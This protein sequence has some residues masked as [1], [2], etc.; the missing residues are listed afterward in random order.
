MLEIETRHDPAERKFFA[1]VDGEEARL[2]YAPTGERTLD[3]RHTF[4]PER[5]RS[6]GIG[7]HLVKDALDH[8]REHGTRVIP[9]CPFVRRIIERNP[10]YSD[11]LAEDG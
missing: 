11:L 9:T 10:E 1:V 7:E 4:V 6:R 2:D 5:L 3:Y 8:A